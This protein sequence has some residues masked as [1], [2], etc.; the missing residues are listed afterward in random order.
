MATVNFVMEKEVSVEVENQDARIEEQSRTRSRVFVVSG[1]VNQMFTHGLVDMA[2]LI[3][4][5][6]R[7]F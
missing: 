1:S 7:N 2:F 4:R 5:N 3:R 6:R